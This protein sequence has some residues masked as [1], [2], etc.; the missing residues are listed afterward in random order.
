MRFGLIALALA[1]TLAC[2]T[3]KTTPPAETE[4]ELTSFYRDLDEDGFG[5]PDLVQEDCVDAQ[6]DGYI[7]EAGDC[8]DNAA[9]VNPD[10]VEICDGRDEDCSGVVDDNAEGSSFYY[11]D[12]DGDGYGDATSSIQSCSQPPGYVFGNTDCDDGD[13]DVYPGAEEVCDGVDQDCDGMPD[14]GLP[15]D[16]YYADTDGDG[17]GD[18]EAEAELCAPLDGWVRN[19]SDCND[20]NADI[21]PSAPELCNG[22]DDDCDGVVDDEEDLAYTSWYTDGDGDGYGDPATEVRLCDTP[23]DLVDLGGDCD[24]ANPDVNPGGTEI[25]NGLDDDCDLAVDDADPSVDPSTATTWFPDADGDGYGDASGPFFSCSAPGASYVLDDTDCD[26]DNV[27]LNP[28]ETEICN[29]LD[30]DCDALVDLDDPDVDL[31]VVPTWYTDVDGDGFGD[32]AD[33]VDACTVDG[34]S[35]DGT[36]CDDSDP[37]IFPGAPEICEDGVDD[38]CDGSD[39]SCDGHMTEPF[40]PTASTGQWCYGDAP[41]NWAYFGEMTFDECQVIANTTGTQWYVGQYTSY[42]YGWIGDDDGGMAVAS[43]ASWTTEDIVSRTTLKSCT[44]GQVEHR[45]EPTVSPSAQYY[46]DAAG[47]DWVYW[48]IINQTH[49]QAMAFADDRGARIIAPESVGRNGEAWMTALTH[50][51]SAGA[52]Y[53]TASYCNSD[54]ICSFLVGYWE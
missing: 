42:P 20:S 36:D 29:G 19:L 39:R 38:D 51:C 24:D 43:G 33:F 21:S 47:R 35:L 25:C 14:D 1:G 48:E 18:P 10:Q 28:G 6:V 11:A 12:S 37:L 7:L 27:D 3:D 50:W 49:S 40:F 32:P 22:R 53:N 26:D 54:N 34:A 9:N 4:C 31:S 44:L 8:D 30:D 2:T 16:I 46:T 5:D 23:K 45:T 52:G 15:G 13:A 17:Y 41:V